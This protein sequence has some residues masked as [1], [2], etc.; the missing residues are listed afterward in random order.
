MVSTRPKGL[1]VHPTEFLDD[2]SDAKRPCA[3]CLRSHAYAV[4]HAPKDKPAPPYPDCTYDEGEVVCLVSL[5]QTTNARSG[6]E[7]PEEPQ[8]T[9]KYQVLENRI[10][11]SFFVSTA[12]TELDLDCVRRRT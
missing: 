8:S 1:Y 5:L 7:E 3:T 4:A 2:F 6:A 10:S 11:Q 9:V 12:S